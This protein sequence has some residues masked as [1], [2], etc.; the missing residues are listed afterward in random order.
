MAERILSANREQLLSTDDEVVSPLAADIAVLLPRIGSGAG[1]TVLPGW[2]IILTTENIGSLE[3]LTAD[4]ARVKWLDPGA[5]CTVVAVSEHVGWTATDAPLILPAV[6][7]LGGGVGGPHTHPISDIDGLQIAL[8]S[9]A[10][11]VHTHVISD[12]TG[13]QAALDAKAAASHSHAQSDVTG[14]PAALTGK[15]DVGHTHT[16]AEVASGVLAI[17][18]I[19][20]GATGSTVPFGN[21]ARFSDARTPLAHTHPAADVI[22]GTL[23]IARVP[24]GTTGSTVPFGNDAR[25]SDSRNPLA[26]AVNHKAAGTDQIKLDELAAPTDI[27][28]LNADTSKHG[29]LPKLGGGTTNFLRAD[30]TWAAPGGGGGADP[31]S[32]AKVSGADFTTSSATAVDVTGLGFTPAANTSYEFECFLMLRTA[33]ATVNPRAG[34]AWP[35]GGTDGVAM[36]SESQAANTAPLAANGNI[37]AALLIAVGGLP[38]TTQSWP[39]W[40]EGM[41]IAGAS[42]SGNVRVQLASETAGTVVRVVIGSFIRWRALP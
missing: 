4:N 2:A 33:T 8:D 6:R 35:T 26:H 23:D 15:S 11:D 41:F 29:L 5:S 12:T 18:R 30:G 16:A 14:L 36:I 21:D 13:L 32:Y 1:G 40:I 17:G 42:P 27:T 22:S 37:N 24:T 31:W 34:L 28:T 25:F 3:I 39:A 20:T 38:N 7:V 9:K 19:P 10:D